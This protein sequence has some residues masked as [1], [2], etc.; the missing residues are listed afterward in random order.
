MTT[1]EFLGELCQKAG[2]KSDGIYARGRIEHSSHPQWVG[3]QATSYAQRVSYS[4]GETG[5][6]MSPRDLALNTNLDL[7]HSQ[8]LP[9][10]SSSSF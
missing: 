3:L 10:A 8:Q 7:E 9:G 5:S 1:D 4:Q 6:P 2:M